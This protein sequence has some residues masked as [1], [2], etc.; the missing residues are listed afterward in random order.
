MHTN[1]LLHAVLPP[2]M[3]F[4][5]PRPLCAFRNQIQT[6]TDASLPLILYIFFTS[7]CIRIDI[8]LSSSSF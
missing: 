7:F 4:I 2:L 6:T 5:G 8:G 3:L 1:L